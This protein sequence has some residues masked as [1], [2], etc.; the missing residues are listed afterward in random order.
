MIY[1][2]LDRRDSG[3]RS[4]FAIFTHFLRELARIDYSARTLVRRVSRAI[5]IASSSWEQPWRYGSVMAQEIYSV[6]LLALWGIL[7]IIPINKF[8]RFDAI[9]WWVLI[10]EKNV[11]WLVRNVYK[12]KSTEPSCGPMIDPAHCYIVICG[13]LFKLW[14]SNNGTKS[15]KSFKP[16]NWTELP[17][18]SESLRSFPR[19]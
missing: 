9:V 12:I 13:R 18:L 3:M 14:L 11:W 5:V 8:W 17:G 15:K 7:R 4:D 19:L 6:R 16:P 1:G 10:K 2:V